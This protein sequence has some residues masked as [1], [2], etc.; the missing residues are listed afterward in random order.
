MLSDSIKMYVKTEI[1][2]FQMRKKFKIMYKTLTLNYKSYG[3]LFLFV[4]N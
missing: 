3:I 2:S 4:L 1:I